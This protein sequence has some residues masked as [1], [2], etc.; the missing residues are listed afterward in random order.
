MG[1][2]SVRSTRDKTGQG[3]F[4][5]NSAN[6]AAFL[7]HSEC[8]MP[9][10]RLINLEHQQCRNLTDH[11]QIMG[12]TVRNDGPNLFRLRFAITLAAGLAGYSRD[13]NSPQFSAS[14]PSALVTS[15]TVSSPLAAHSR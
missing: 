8:Q 6:A 5:I 10:Q 7:N 12:E 11:T 3:D 13:L 4:K 15:Q 1:K 9:A 2:L 14:N